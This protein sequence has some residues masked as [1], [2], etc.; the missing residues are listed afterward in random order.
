V[1]AVPNLALLAA[2][3]LLT[4]CSPTI[5]FVA[6]TDPSPTSVGDPLPGSFHL[7]SEP[8]LAPFRMTIRIDDIG[9]PSRRTAEFD[10]GDEVVMDW[11]TLPLPEEKW[12]EVNGQDCLGT[13]TIQE[14][15]VT[16]L[17]MMLSDSG[18]RVDVVGSHP[19]PT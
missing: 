2:A 13:F 7:T 1:V 9:G 4:A 12:L 10:T 16:V 19:E 17:Q 8:K 14:R 15:V 18:C 5:Q 11:S 3:L 6:P